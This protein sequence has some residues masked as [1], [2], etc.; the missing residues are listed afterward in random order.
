[1]HT[2]YRSNTYIPELVQATTAKLMKHNQAEFIHGDWK[3]VI[4]KGP[5]QFIIADAAAAKTIEGELLFKSL[6]IG[7]MLFMD[8][9]TPEEHFP[10][11]WKGKPDG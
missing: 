2:L 9:F 11:E 1:M 3:E 7:G 6:A 5:F 8:D 10:E 4:E